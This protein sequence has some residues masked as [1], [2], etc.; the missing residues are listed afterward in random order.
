M[1]CDDVSRANVES[2]KQVFSGG[3][4]HL[5]IEAAAAEEEKKEVAT[6]SV[7]ELYSKI[8]HT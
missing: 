6:M 7:S 2:A 4:F 8:F 1:H 3:G 5:E